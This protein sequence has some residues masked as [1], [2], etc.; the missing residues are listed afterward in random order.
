SSGRAPPATPSAPLV[1]GRAARTGEVEICNA[2][3]V[4]P[5]VARG[6]TIEPIA[7]TGLP[8]GMFRDTRFTINRM[9]LSPGDTILLYTDGVNET[10]DAAGTEFGIDRLRKHLAGHHTRRPSELVAGFLSELQQFR[11]SA[12]KTDDLTLMAVRRVE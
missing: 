7:A 2:G 11:D 4:P 9:R 3:H 12:P 1:G 6:A 10:L 8:I 5:L